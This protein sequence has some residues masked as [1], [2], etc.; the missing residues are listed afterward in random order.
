[1]K[2][3]EALIRVERFPGQKKR[4]DKIKSVKSRWVDWPGQSAKLQA[5]QF[6]NGPLVACRSLETELPSFMTKS[7]LKNYNFIVDSLMVNFK[8][9]RLYV[10]NFQPK[11]ENLSGGR[12]GKIF[13]EPKQKAIVRLEYELTK[14]SLNTVL[15]RGTGGIKLKGE[16][17]RYISQYRWDKDKWILHENK[18]SVDL[19]YLDKLDKRFV[20]ATH[21]ELSF[22]STESREISS[23]MIKETDVLLSTDQFRRANGLGLSFWTNQNHLMAIP[24]M[25]N[26]TVNRRR[27]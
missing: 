12:S 11:S 7:G 26:I 17:L 20:A 23:S 13:I 6:G 22:L 5:W 18:V 14:K 1:M 21:W 16:S 10:V 9:T 15:G 3:K 25:E 27:R 19:T 2:V 8:D 4:P 24:E